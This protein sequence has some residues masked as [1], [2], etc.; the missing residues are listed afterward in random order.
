MKLKPRFCD[1]YNNLASAYLQLGQ[2]QDAIETYQVRAYE[3]PRWALG[4]RADEDATSV[5]TCSRL[6][7]SVLCD[8][9]TWSV[10]HRPSPLLLP[11]MYADTAVVSCR[12]RAGAGVGVGT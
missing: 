12:L 6:L 3:C 2:T 8:L 11:C 5:R 7:L 4:T 1:A 10:L 9:D